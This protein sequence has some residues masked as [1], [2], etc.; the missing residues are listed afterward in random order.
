VIA[1]TDLLRQEKL[2]SSEFGWLAGLTS[3]TDVT[4]LFPLRGPEVSIGDRDNAVLDSFKT[5]S[6]LLPAGL[7]VVGVFYPSSSVVGEMPFAVLHKEV[8]ENFVAVAVD[9]GTIT[10]HTLISGKTPLEVVE[11]ADADSLIR[12]CLSARVQLRVRCKV[13][14]QIIQRTQLSLDSYVVSALSSSADAFEN[15]TVVMH[16]VSKAFSLRTEESRTV[17]ILVPEVVDKGKKEK[18]K[19]KRAAATVATEA[20]TG[21]LQGELH[22]G[23]TQSG[24]PT[25]PAVMAGLCDDGTIVHQGSVALDVFAYLDKGES[26]QKAARLIIATA[27]AQLAYAGKFLSEDPLCVPAAYVVDLPISTNAS[28]K[29]AT[30]Y[31]TVGNNLVDKFAPL[32]RELH[33][34]LRLP[35]DRP[36][37]R[38][39]NAIPFDGGMSEAA[40]TKRLVNPH[41]GL[42]P[43]GVEDGKLHLVHDFYDYY[44]YMQDGINDKGW[45][46]A[47]R[48]LQT[49]VS[50]YQKQHY[51][52][53]EV[54]MHRKIQEI[55]VECEDKPRTFI[56][57]TNWIGSFEVSMVLDAYLDVPCN[58]I[59]CNQGVELAD[60]GREL[61]KHF[62]EVGTPVMMGGGELAFTCIGIDY[63]ESLGQIKFLILDPHY[64]GKDD[65]KA[66]QG[67]WVG[68]Q[69]LDFFDQ[70]AF[71][72]L[73]CPQRLNVV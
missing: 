17:A 16:S 40:S 53:K 67:R 61:R 23:S 35:L 52:S 32:R 15:V 30:L 59:T 68:W 3:D 49:I 36:M 7:Q 9:E 10:A 24:I 54:P 31:P 13:P 48:S 14:L 12:D 29:F 62:E 28:C 66:V 72:N 38:T 47:Y 2:G 60:K 57:S 69:S 27:Q 22:F 58:M 51:T 25:A 11:S 41:E 55:L 71:Y 63:N 45:G 19:G 43:S 70:Y 37:L 6:S 5:V 50:W 42:P 20:P 65:L 44:H 18:Q 56:N 4:A 1:A 73:C 8:P 33:R 34:V 26:L 64:T 39:E 46:C 21:P